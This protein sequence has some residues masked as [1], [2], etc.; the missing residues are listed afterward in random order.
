MMQ[1]RQ[2]K[3]FIIRHKKKYVFLTVSVMLYIVFLLSYG[4]KIPWFDKHPTWPYFPEHTNPSI[5]IEQVYPNII[6]ESIVKQNNNK[7]ELIFAFKKDVTPTCDSFFIFNT[8][9]KL[10]LA[11]KLPAFYIG[12][13]QFLYPEPENNRV[14]IKLIDTFHFNEDK[15]KYIAYD[16][17]NFKKINLPDNYESK[18]VD[19]IS[20]LYSLS[21]VS[22][23]AAINKTNVTNFKK[24]GFIIT[25]N[26]FVKGS[27]WDRFHIS[28]GYNST[29]RSYESTSRF[30]QTG[31]GYFELSVKGSI[32]N[33]K[34]INEKNVYNFF[35]VAKDVNKHDTLFFS[36]KLNFYKSYI[37]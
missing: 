22:N 28:S 20:K 14:I 35:E 21:I 12:N 10:L 27:W 5:V 33:F 8:Q 4:Y 3:E 13:Y 36:Y 29:G 37:N 26:E 1:K 2:I 32:T 18:L 17:T 24:I 7:G 16:F 30:A 31:I 15:F 6:F 19:S 34:I 23:K 25:G 9:F 11:K